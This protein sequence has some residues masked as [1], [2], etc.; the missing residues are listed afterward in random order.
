MPNIRQFRRSWKLRGYTVVQGRDVRA[1]DDVVRRP[2]FIASELDRHMRDTLFQ[3]SIV[4]MFTDVFGVSMLGGLDDSRLSDIKTR[5][6]HAFQTGRLVLVRT[7]YRS[8]G[9]PGTKEA[10]EMP[11]QEAEVPPP[12][13]APHGAP[14]PV[15]T[16]VE[17]KLVDQDGKPVPNERYR[18]KLPDGS[19][20]D[21]RLNDSGSVR[22]DGIDPGNCDISFPDLDTK[23]WKAA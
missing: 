21:G 4:Q 16:F 15:K 5:L 3:R 1:E 7:S 10:P 14:A 11:P 23:D 19:V 8:S 12:A 13:P 9:S 6:S 20:K 18:L 17:V 22:F 2:L